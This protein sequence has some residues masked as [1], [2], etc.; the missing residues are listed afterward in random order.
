MAGSDAFFVQNVIYYTAA[1]G[2]LVCE[3]ASELLACF[4]EPSSYGG[5]FILR[6]GHVLLDVS[7][8]RVPNRVCLWFR[9]YSAY[10]N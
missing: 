9:A 5:I 2:A 10:L 6:I 1:P 4:D 3:Y 8:Y 7:N